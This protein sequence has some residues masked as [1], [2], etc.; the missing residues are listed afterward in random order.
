[1]LAVA[2]IAMPQPEEAM[3]IMAAPYQMAMPSAVMIAEGIWG[4]SIRRLRR[5]RLLARW[6]T[7]VLGEA[8]KVAAVRRIFREYVDLG[9]S[10][11]RIADGLN[12]KRIAAP[13]E[14]RWTVRQVLACLRAKSHA[15]TITYRRKTKPSRGK[16]DQ[17]FRATK[18]SERVVSVEQF[19][20]TQEMLA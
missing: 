10:T 6:L 5:S 17:W 7:L 14:D 13:R 19:Q 2:V 20:R 8:A 4:G 9:Y 16:A 12:A 18:G 11:A 3:I 15:A 1:L